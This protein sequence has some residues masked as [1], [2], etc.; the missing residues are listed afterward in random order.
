MGRCGYMK[1]ANFS[2]TSFIRVTLKPELRNSSRNPLPIA[3]ISLATTIDWQHWL[4]S[5][6]RENAASGHQ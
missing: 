4:D 1:A 3:A 2:P 6:H 5:H